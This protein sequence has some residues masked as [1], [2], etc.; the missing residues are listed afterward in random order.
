MK[1]I[2]QHRGHKEK[3]KLHREKKIFVSFVYPLCSLWL[4]FCFF[5]LFSCKPKEAKIPAGILPKEQ[6]VSV[7]TD[8]HLA[9]AALTLN[10]KNDSA[11]L[12]AAGYYNFIYQS[13]RITKKQFDESL[14]FYTKHPELLEKIY[15]E[16]INELS[17]KQ[18][19]AVNH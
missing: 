17:K 15:E 11:A 19:E 10:T 9:E 4:I 8:V 16:V 2:F 5:F 6:M 7:L 12:V 14:D 13:H 3:I 1:K 18:A